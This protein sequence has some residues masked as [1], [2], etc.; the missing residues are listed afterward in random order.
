MNGL[1]NKDDVKNELTKNA[2]TIIENYVIQKGNAY[3]TRYLSTKKYG[4][5]PT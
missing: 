1:N 3:I 4:F 5:N 2:F